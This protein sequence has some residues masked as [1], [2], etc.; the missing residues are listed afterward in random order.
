M[1]LSRTMVAIGDS[2]GSLTSIAGARGLTQDPLSG[3]AALKDRKLSIYRIAAPK[4]TRSNGSSISSTIE[5]LKLETGMVIQPVF[6]QGDALMI[7]SD[8]VIVRFTQDTSLDEARKYLAAY[9]NSVGITGIRGHRKNTYILTINNPSDGRCYAVCQALSKLEGIAFAEPNHI[10]VTLDDQEDAAGMNLPTPELPKDMLLKGQ[11]LGGGSPDPPA[12]VDHVSKSAVSWTTLVSEGFES[13][14]AGWTTSNVWNPA[15]G[16]V[17]GIWPYR[18]HSGSY[19]AYGTGG[20]VWGNAPPGP[21]FG[22][23]SNWLKSP[24]LN[25]ASYKEV[26]VELWFYAKYP[27]PLAQD[28]KEYVEAGI[29]D[30]NTSTFKRA[31]YLGTGYTGDC[32]ADPTTANGWRK[33]LYRVEPSLRKNNVNAM[34]LFLSDLGGTEGIY[35][36]D[37]RIV[38]TTN[39]DAN[40]IS[41]DKYDAREYE[42]NNSGQIAGLGGD[43]NDLHIPEAW[44]LVSVSPDIVVAVVD[45]GVELTHPDLNLVTGYDSNGAV[46]GG[47]KTA[48]ENHGTSCAGNVGAIGNNGIG[49]VGTAPNVKIMPVHRGSQ[50]AD[51][52]TALDAA[53]AHGADILSNSWGWV[54]SPSSDI[55]GAIDDALGAGVI[56]VFAAGNG[57]DRD[58]FTY[59]VAWPGCLTGSKDIITVGASS[60]TDE[61]KATASSDGEHSWGSSYIGDGPDIVAPGPWSYTTDRS[62]SA[63]YNDGSLIDPTDPSS[64]A[65]DPTFGGTSS[66]TPK[67]SGIVALM[68]SA[69]PYLSSAQV[70]SILRSTATCIG[71]ADKVGAGRV[72]AYAAVQAAAAIPTPTPTPTAVPTCPPGGQLT[73]TIEIPPIPS[74]VILDGYSVV[75]FPNN[76]GFKTVWNN[77]IRKFSGPLV[78]GIHGLPNGYSGT[79]LNMKVPE[80]APVGEYT[81]TVGLVYSGTSPRVDSSF[82]FKSEHKVRI[83]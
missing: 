79:L 60:Q 36:D 23:F 46:G 2:A 53:V 49:V 44:G 77:S 22:G 47:P 68:L 72:N 6:A 78:R 64:A 18:H 20:G 17:W 52:A 35:I 31:Q 30:N 70:K 54:G 83:E 67:V 25:L 55:E 7:P 13:V 48:D 45:C 62:G 66:S 37:V 27:V 29:W 16:A 56:V 15:T 81:F 50:V 1:N 14:P 8:E 10:V 34:F 39:V 3:H 12:P 9:M 74:S 33:A 65:Y 19:S 61:H 58:P 42:L 69:N 71:D 75:F 24:T 82:Y 63:G 73:I 51:N 28:W 32:T 26:Y 38:A 59:E 57:P 21:Y 40:H 80:S 76:K 5:S 43:D 4:G 11:P 41:N